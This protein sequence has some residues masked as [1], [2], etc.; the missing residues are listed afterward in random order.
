MYFQFQGTF[1]LMAGGLLAIAAAILIKIFQ[2]YDLIFRWKLIF[3]EGGEI[4]N[5][6]EKPPVDLYVKIYLFNITNAD[7]F[8]EG[9]ENLRVEE[10]G[11]YVYKEILQHGDVVFNDNNTI[12]TRPRH[13]LVFDQE[14]SGE[15][16]EDDLLMM[17]NI[18]LL[19]IA[20][21]AADKSYFVRL[22]VNILIRQTKSLPIVR[23]TAHEFMFGYETQLTTLGNTFLPDWIIFDKVGLIDRMYDFN[24]DYETF[25]TGAD[26]PSIS[27]L[28]ATYR[29]SKDLPQWSGDEHCSNIQMASDGTKFKSF[30]QP[31]E[32]A[33][34]FRKSMCRAQ[35]LIPTGEEQVV[36]GLQAYRFV[37]EENALDNGYYNE[38]N[39]C[40]CRKG[41]CQPRGLS[42]VTDCYYGF[43]ISLSYPHFLDS[44]PKLLEAVHGLKPNRSKHESH[45]MINPTSGL[46][47]SC[48]V[49]FQINMHMRDIRSMAHVERF[50]DMTLPMLWFEIAMRELPKPLE[51]RFNL[52]LNILPYIEPVGFWGGLVVG[53]LCLIFA[54][55]QAVVKLPQFLSSSQKQ[56]SN[57]SRFEK[58]TFRSSIYQPCEMKLMEAKDKY[59]TKPQHGDD[60]I[61]I[62]SID[63]S[64]EDNHVMDQ[65]TSNSDDGNESTSSQHY[66]NLSEDSGSQNS[67]ENKNYQKESYN[68]DSYERSRLDST[69]EKGSWLMGEA[70]SSVDD[71]GT[72][73]FSSLINS[74][75]D[76]Y[77][78]EDKEEHTNEASIV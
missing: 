66:A 35:K 32:T 49:R 38:K 13:P 10:V 51:S 69:E 45:F 40:F 74:D 56:Y 26:N 7:A 52:Y 25:Y 73:Q 21:V 4:F 19:S 75:D 27:G 9:R 65:V 23:M 63:I 22:P 64:G 31:N 1:L 59:T 76:D 12:S 8:M 72:D 54:I 62:C 71:I 33:L 28:Y 41:Y 5:L 42:D 36:S 34:F 50:S 24:S 2:P 18:A 77:D 53:A 11:P 30:M 48:S 68:N 70:S 78:S 60:E 20:Q 47:L 16:R 29:G 44:D 58:S 43:P 6:W 46:P 15:R 67:G 37:F 39:K 61:M 55:V 17:V 3:E 14:L 57:N